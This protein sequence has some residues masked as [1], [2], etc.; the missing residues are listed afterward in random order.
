MSTLSL[1]CLIP[2]ALVVPEHVSLWRLCTALIMKHR[3]KRTFK[4]DVHCVMSCQSHAATLKARL[5]TAFDTELNF[6]LKDK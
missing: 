6:A 2:S 1:L 3:M 5:S 4:N